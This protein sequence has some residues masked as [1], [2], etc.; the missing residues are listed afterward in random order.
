[1]FLSSPLRPITAP[2]PH[3]ATPID[4]LRDDPFTGATAVELQNE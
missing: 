2:R 3:D 1:M 4:D